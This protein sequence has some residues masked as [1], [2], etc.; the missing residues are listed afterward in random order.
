M[1]K[2]PFLQELVEA[3]LF[4][5][6]NTLKGKSVEDIASIV[7]LM[8]MMLE[9]SRHSYH[10]FASD[11]A[12]KTM[13]YNTYENMHYSG[14][15]LGNLLAVL[16]NQDTFK[17]YIKAA[18]GIS[19]P[20]FQINRYLQACKG[21][22]FN[23]ND[24]ATFFW[25]L[26]D[27]L[28]LY[29]K[30]NFRILRR[31]VGD[32]K[33]LSFAERSRVVL[34]L[35]QEFDKRAS[36]CDIYL[37]W[38]GS[39]KL[40]ESV[41]E[42]SLLELASAKTLDTKLGYHSRLNPALWNNEELIPEVKDALG[43]IAN[44]FSEFIDVKQIKI[45][46]Y[47]I[48]GSNCAFNYTDESDIDIHVVVDASKL[49]D[50]PLTSPFLLAKKALWNSGHNI[51]VKGYDVEL[52][53]EDANDENNKLVATGI[54]SLL[55]DKWIKKPEYVKVQYDDA[56]VKSKAADIMNQIDELISTGEPDQAQIDKL[57]EHI[58]KMR[59]SGLAAT[60][61]FG[62]ENLAFKAVRN[63]DYFNKLREFERMREDDDLTLEQI[64]Q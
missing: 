38:K 10:S 52:Y 42:S 35:R 7:Y 24:D 46:D 27:Y 57:W 30:G 22:S 33:R 40:Q 14:T 56:A 50:N 28:K 44:K 55:Q 13:A 26:E 4:T 16:N 12:N 34:I 49:G 39:F 9:I 17:G 29:S 61:E 2:L 15:D 31:D 41:N 64:V 32:W 6:A 18:S 3:R 5:D 54:Y 60:G 51:T 63:N 25:R 62:V 23:H 21:T 11:Y 19:I 58:Y 43:K 37:W 8:I 1:N 45:I 48:T 20:L 53:A 36:S 47:V 59:R